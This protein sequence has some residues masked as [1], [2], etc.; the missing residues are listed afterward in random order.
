MKAVSIFMYVRMYLRMFK[1]Q[2]FELRAD[3]DTYK[4]ATTYMHK[5]IQTL[6]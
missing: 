2:A 5:Y 4:S 6:R 3:L 1:L